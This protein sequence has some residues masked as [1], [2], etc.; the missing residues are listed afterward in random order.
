MFNNK[1]LVYALLAVS[2]TA[3]AAPPPSAGSQMQQ[4]PP[5]SIPQKIEPIIET[6]PTLE[7]Q[8]NSVPDATETDGTKIVVK[9]LKIAGAHAYSESD[10]LAVTGFKAGSE[11]SLFELR[12][13]AKKIADYYHRNGYF[14][15]QA[16]LPAQ[17]I[18]DATV[19]IAVIDGQYGNITLNN[20]TN[21][22]NDL[23]NNM[24]AGVNSGDYVTAA[25]LERRL[26]LLSDV[27]G[28][29][30]KSTLA[31][32]VSVGASDLLV[33]ITPGQ[34]VTGS[35]DADNAGNRYTGEYRLGA[36]INLNDPTGHGDLA[37]L[38]VLT[39]GSGLNYARA[40]YQMQFG[41]AKA[42]VAYS[43]LEY[44][45]GKE[46][47]SLQ[48]HGTVTVAS[49]YGSY[50][51]IRSR[52]NNLYAQLAY[53]DKTFK[54]K[55]DLTDSVTDKKAQVLMGS[56]YGDRRDRFSG[57]GLSTYSLTLSLGNLD[58]KTPSVH[59]VDAATANTDGH[60]S[61]LAFNAL[62]LQSMTENFSLYAAIN[63][64]VA[65]KNLDVSEK[66][67]LGGMY[68][69]RAYPEGE[70]N[71]DNGYVI[72]LEARA[73]L[74]KFSSILPGQMQLIAFVDTGYVKTYKNPWTADTNHLRLSGAGLGVD[75]LQFNNFELKAY[76]AHKLGN[77]DATSAPD[78][79]GRFWIQVVKYF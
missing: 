69:V 8:Q 40:S 39:A 60:Y 49:I 41:N 11:L 42:G 43:Y 78:R 59:I 45:L 62:R 22:N 1:Y 30:V 57:G 75:W 27:P 17:D 14:V 15:A 34:R 38:R 33:D 31:P 28:V 7:S 47:E 4:I 9:H 25:P 16:Y 35:I 65:S 70:A 77:T 52:D 46:F 50:P 56:L 54:D 67:E 6:A 2:H 26:L 73:N 37:T 29:K 20:Q 61:K 63:G 68:A 71:A 55:V 44:A 66:M 13:M 5:G 19:T 36:T 3:L 72:N 18:V 58:I 48:A 51:L 10:L 53:D 64:Q 12:G 24:L 79:S 76:Y 32:G 23:A 74:P 21:L